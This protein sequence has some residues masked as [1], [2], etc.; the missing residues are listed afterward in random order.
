MEVFI[1]LRQA[2]N[3]LA[4]ILTTDEI[5]EEMDETFNCCR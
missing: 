4:T 5:E 2:E 3:E 1:E